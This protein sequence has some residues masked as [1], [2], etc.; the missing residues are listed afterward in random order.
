MF[1]NV[2]EAG[3]LRVLLRM[4]TSG[5]FGFWFGFLAAWYH[6][7][8]FSILIGPVLDLFVFIVGRICHI[9]D[10]CPAGFSLRVGGLSSV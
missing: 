6:S 2:S 7:L 8:C 5:R 9:E 10:V 4:E 1:L 3:L